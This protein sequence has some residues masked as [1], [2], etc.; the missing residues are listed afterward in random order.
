VTKK[1]VLVAPLDWGLGHATRCIPII[2]KLLELDAHVAIASSGKALALLKEEFP[3]LTYFE[4]PSY[5]VTYPKGLPFMLGMLW[6]LPKFL[7][8][9][10]QEKKV[11]DELV[12][13]HDFDIILS[14]NRYGCRSER[15]TSV[16][17][18]HQVT[19]L[20]PPLLRWVQ[21]LVNFLNRR[22]ISRFDQCWV[23]DIPVKGITGKLTTT[24][25]IKLRFIGMLSRFRWKE[26]LT[27]PIYELLILLSGP[28]PQRTILE[29]KLLEQ[30]KDIKGNALLVR[31]LPDQAV[32]KPLLKKENAQLIVVNHL[33]ST[34]LQ[35]AIES[36]S[37]IITRS[38]YS[39][40]MDLFRLQKKAILVPTP[41][42]TEQ[43]YLAD[44]LMK[45]KIAFAMPQRTFNLQQALREATTYSGFPAIVNRQDW[46]TEEILSILSRD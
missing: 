43:E 6:Q 27:E 32:I 2:E 38:G 4:L 37:I 15:A 20:M 33:P 7:K 17:I 30:I 28:E 46:L 14:D 42:Q 3:Q 44:Q 25:R 10:R 22:T 1:R 24:H 34:K 26:V 8:T 12:N 31:G 18:T 19:I 5:R 40:I 13:K 9:I 36:S 39:T 35:E 45:K 16:F 41:G 11:T 23:P 29:E 21:P